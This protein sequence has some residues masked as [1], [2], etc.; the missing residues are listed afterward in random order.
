MK[1]LVIVLAL[2]AGLGNAYAN[3]S[4]PAAPKKVEVKVVDGLKFKV[5]IPELV[6]KGSVS[7]KNAAGDVIYR[8]VIGETPAF[9]KVY[10][11]AGFPDGDY[12]FEVRVAGKVI[13]KD[14]KINTTTNRVA[15]VN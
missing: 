1:K 5:T 7:I 14:I 13:S 4:L 6:E 8:E 15:S 11:L 12:A 3:E 9:V 2:L 10:N